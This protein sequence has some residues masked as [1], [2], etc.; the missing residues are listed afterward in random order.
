MQELK[1]WNSW[2]SLTKSPTILTIQILVQDPIQII[3][4]FISFSALLLV[5]STFQWVFNQEIR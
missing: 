2:P 4:I 5:S 1:T 3:I